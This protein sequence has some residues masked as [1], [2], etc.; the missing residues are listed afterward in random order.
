MHP[1][2]DLWLKVNQGHFRKFTRADLRGDGLDTGSQQ[3][4][5]IMNIDNDDM[6]VH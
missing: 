3:S 1:G 4:S 6:M 2:K 5:D